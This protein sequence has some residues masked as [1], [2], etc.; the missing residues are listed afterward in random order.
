[1]KRIA[2]MG[3]LVSTCVAA[4]CSAQTDE[5][6]PRG[7]GNQSSGGIAELGYVAYS[8]E[9]AER[10][11]STIAGYVREKPRSSASFIDAKMN[12]RITIAAYQSGDFRGEKFEIELMY[13]SPTQAP[14]FAHPGVVSLIY[15]PDGV[16]APFWQGRNE[17]VVI[18]SI[19]PT[20]SAAHVKATFTAELCRKESNSKPIDEGSCVSTQGVIDTKLQT[21]DGG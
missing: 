7:G 15:R 12:P 10:R 1:M 19:E 8:F 21:P 9:G 3:V 14:D 6:Q 5:A 16:L 17:K 20:G 18:E 4:A 11:W 2:I 13:P